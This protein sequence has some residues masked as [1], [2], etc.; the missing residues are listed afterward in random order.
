MENTDIIQKI[1]EGDVFL[2]TREEM[3]LLL[4]WLRNTLTTQERKD[5]NADLCQLFSRIMRLS[6]R[7]YGTESFNRDTCICNG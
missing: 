5:E 2:L 7:L 6:N 1:Q 3:A 4:P